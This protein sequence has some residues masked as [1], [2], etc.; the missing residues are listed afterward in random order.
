[1]AG[2]GATAAVA[3][4]FDAVMDR[5]L[6]RSS[7]DASD[8][9]DSL[10]KLPRDKEKSRRTY[11]ADSTNPAQPVPNGNSPEQASSSPARVAE[12]SKPQSGTSPGVEGVSGSGQTTASS[13]TVPTGSSSAVSGPLAKSLVE[14][15]SSTD[16]QALPSTEGTTVEDAA[17]LKTILAKAQAESGEQAA[18]SD[19]I[20]TEIPAAGESGLQNHGTGAPVSSAGAGKLSVP[21][22]VTPGSS[23]MTGISS[24]QHQVPMQKADKTNEFSATAEQNVPVPPAGVTGEELPGRIVRSINSMPRQ[25]KSEPASSLSFA[26]SGAT[27][28]AETISSVN[29]SSQWPSP[30]P[31]RALERAHDLMALHAFRLRDSGA[32]SMQVVIK[33]GHGMQL[34]LSL[35][36]RDGNLEMSAT[37]HRGDYNFLNRHWSELQQQLEARGVRLAPL[38]CNNQAGAGDKNLSQ[39]PDRQKAEEETTIPGAFAG[40]ALGAAMKP[41]TSTRIKTPS[42]WESWA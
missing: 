42:G 16:A 21:E 1:M 20:P 22:A 32:D 27:S 11:Q 25:D 29:P 41:A 39:Q 31:A 15:A 14:D 24:A 30:D 26:P 34:S 8:D 23:D 10:N 37:M 18:G 35:Q 36:M 7:N 19:G 4:H 2:P 3:H 40:F 5:A 17:A 28:P 6:S 9:S 38:T 13:S 12:G 33:P